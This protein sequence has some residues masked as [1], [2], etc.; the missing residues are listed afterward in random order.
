VLAQLSTEIALN[1]IMVGRYFL[2]KIYASWGHCLYDIKSQLHKKGVLQKLL[3]VIKALW[4]EDIDATNPLYGLHLALVPT[5][6]LPSGN[7]LENS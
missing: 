4:Q 2:F 5:S 3:K 7:S 1:I 6:S